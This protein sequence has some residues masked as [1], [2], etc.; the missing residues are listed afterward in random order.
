MMLRGSTNSRCASLEPPPSCKLQ[1]H[2]QL[3]QPQSSNFRVYGYKT[4]TI[5]LKTRVR[6]KLCSLPTVVTFEHIK[7][8]T[9]AALSCCEYALT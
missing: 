5:N 6:T 3:F 1:T 4:L 8:H 2:L 7:M 9:T